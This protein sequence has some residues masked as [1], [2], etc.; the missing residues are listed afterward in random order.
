MSTELLEVRELKTHY[1]TRLKENVYAV[2]DVSFSLDDGKV[3]GIA[4]ES[5]CGKS[6]LAQSL[7]GL[8][9]PPLYFGSGS[10]ILN[11]TDIITRHECLEPHQKDHQLY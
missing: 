10:I 7:M 4:G 8:F 6:T 9:L 11:G 3:L 5:G 2:D 1:R